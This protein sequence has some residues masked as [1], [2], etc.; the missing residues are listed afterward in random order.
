MVCVEVISQMAR[1][2]VSL[3]EYVVQTADRKAAEL[4]ISRSAF[5]AT[6]IQ[7]KVQ[8]DDM[9]REVPK[10]FQLL[11]DVRSGKM[12]PDQMRDALGSG[13]PGVTGTTGGEGL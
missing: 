4:G 5:I 8:Y 3:P 12:T 11:D 2:N 7:F 10:M 6:A 9:M 1:Y 13:V